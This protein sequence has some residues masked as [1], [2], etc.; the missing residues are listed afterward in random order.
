MAVLALVGLAV[1]LAYQH[2]L[3]GEKARTEIAHAA[4]QEQ[5]KK[6]ETYLYINKIVLADASGRSG[7]VSRVKELLQQCPEG[8]RGWEWRYLEPALPPR[9]RQRSGTRNG[10]APRHGV[11]PRRQE[12]RIRR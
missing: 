4:E 10:H 12:G 11:Q 2:R 5:R 8:A 3:E 9:A 1:G 7:N 6:A